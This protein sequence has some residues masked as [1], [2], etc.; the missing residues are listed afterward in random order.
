MPLNDAL[1]IPSA[2]VAAACG[3]AIVLCAVACTSFHLGSASADGGADVAL[4]AR[5][6][7]SHEAGASDGCA[8]LG[9]CCDEAGACQAGTA[10]DLC[11]SVGQACDDCTSYEL[12]CAPVDGG[13]GVCA[14]EKVVTC[15][16]ESCGG[17]CQG[18]TCQIDAGITACGTGGEPCV[19]CPLGSSC[20]AGACVGSETCGPASCVGC[21]AGSTCLPGNTSAA[22]GANGQ[23]CEPCSGAPSAPACYPLSSLGGGVCTMVFGCGPEDCAG[24]CDPFYVCHSGTEQLQCGSGGGPC[25]VCGAGGTCNQHVCS[26]GTC[27]AM[28][29][30]D[31]CCDGF[32]ICQRGADG[33]ACGST[34]GLC[35]TCP[36]GSVCYA[37][38]G[39]CL[40][41]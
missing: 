26:N 40:P 36:A 4:D 21:C 33:A 35:V 11:G 3:A 22:C 41:E 23:A 20:N 9:G 25:G 7:A 38:A 15:T 29:C 2:P 16:P 1:S 28:N 34:A 24:C 17:C 39:A 30:L 19:A 32:G 37:D 31:G 10:I 14:S 6:E 12:P 8:C 18:D 5:I 13:G 27:S